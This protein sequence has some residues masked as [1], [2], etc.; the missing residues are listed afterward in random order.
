[1]HANVFSIQI[2]FSSVKLRRGVA[3]HFN[4][5][6]CYTHQIKNHLLMSVIIFKKNEGII[7]LGYLILFLQYT[8]PVFDCVDHV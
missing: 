5:F 2:H 7:G 8:I 6:H 3:L 4:A 1:M